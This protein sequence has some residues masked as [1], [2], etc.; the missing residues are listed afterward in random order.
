MDS[1]FHTLKLVGR[2]E[3]GAMLVGVSG[4]RQDKS[5]SRTTVDQAAADFDK[6][7][8]AEPYAPMIAG[9]DQV[10]APELRATADGIPA[11]IEP[12][13]DRIEQVLG[14][15]GQLPADFGR[16]T[17]TV[18][19]TARDHAIRRSAETRAAGRARQLAGS[20]APTL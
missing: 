20:D 9:P 17:I 14:I 2:R 19:R 6:R 8:D 3:G 13:G 10:H 12:A 16:G 15:D 18:L 7:L 1:R 11:L 5:G 4:S